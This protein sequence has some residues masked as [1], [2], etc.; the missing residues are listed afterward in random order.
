MATKK[1]TVPQD[2]KLES[3][4]FDLFDALAALDKKD[5]GYYDR[6]SEN[7]RKKFV[8]FMLI[9]WMSAV[10]GSS[11]VQS[12]YLQSIDY[13]ANKHLF[14]EY[15]YKHPKLQ[16]LML[17]AASPGLGKQFH[18]WIP[19]IS[20]KV[21]R[22]QAPA[23]I[24]DIREYYKK[25]YP[26]ANISDIEEVSQV[27][28]EN[29]KKKCRLAELFPNMKQSDIEVMSEVITEEQIREYERDLGN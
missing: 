15:V 22:L 26:K 12:Y 20:L 5:Y 11:D 25:I 29:H 16:W 23:K 2:E 28:V 6:L 3:Q 8:P 4:D 24:K 21:S 9:Q 18:Q 27:F 10:K 19:N 14:N 17:C 13:H 7:Q 1:S